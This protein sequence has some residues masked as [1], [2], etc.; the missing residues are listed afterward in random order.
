MRRR[1]RD[2]DQLPALH[3]D[4]RDGQGPGADRRV[5]RAGQR[6]RPAPAA[7]M[8]ST[9]SSRYQ[10]YAP[11]TADAQAAAADQPDD[12]RPAE[13]R[14]HRL[15]LVLGR[16]VQRRR[17]RRRAGLDERH[18][19]DAARIPTPSD[20][21]PTFP[22]CPDKLF[23][24]HHQPL[25]YFAEL[26]ARHAGARPRTCA[27]RPSSWPLRTTRDEDCNLK[28]VSFIKPV[29]AEN[30]HPGY[31]SEPTAATT[32]STCSRRSRAAACAKDTM[33]DRHLRRV[34]RP[35]GSRAAAR[36]GRRRRARTTSGARA[37]G[38]RRWSSRRACSGDFVVDHT[39]HD[40]TSILATIE[41]RFGLAPLTSRDA[42]V[43]D[44]SSVF[45]RRGRSRHH[46]RWDRGDRTARPPYVA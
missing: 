28:P 16:V 42:A 31:A 44:L 30:E 9:R 11:G 14:G 46:G 15:G 2:A 37:R 23:Q 1:Q 29:G 40:T 39:Q 3:A 35:V 34:R 5:R 6:R 8:P 25:N 41:H 24:F 22:N 18:R 26:R 32:W 36:P 19:P 4:R 17:R 45:R 27:T 7:T 13:R 12:R 20:R 10:P 43:N 21:P 38:S 33:V